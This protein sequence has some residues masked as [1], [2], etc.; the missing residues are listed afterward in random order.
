M[1]RG[2]RLLP[3]SGG[4]IPSRLV[5]QMKNYGQVKGRK[6]HNEQEMPEPIMRK[7]KLCPTCG[8]L[9]PNADFY[10]G[11]STRIECKSCRERKADEEG[12]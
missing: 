4:F 1:Y 2:Y 12:E 7:K 6:W 9:R 3:D 10:V 8:K 11:V 5:Q